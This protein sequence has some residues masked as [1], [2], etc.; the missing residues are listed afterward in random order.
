MS[1]STTF[2]LS[3]IG[4]CFVGN[5]NP[6]HLVENGWFFCVC[7][8]WEIAVYASVGDITAD[9]IGV[10]VDD[11]LSILIISSSATVLL[12]GS[13]GSLLCGLI[14]LFLMLNF[15]AIYL[16]PQFVYFGSEILVF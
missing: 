14:T 3:F 12:G 16:F 1:V 11:G 6:T 8:A 9:A 7:I 2:N 5:S 4:F 10:A 15:C 13:F